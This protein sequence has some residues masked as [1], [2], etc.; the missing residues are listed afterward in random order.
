MNFK[1]GRFFYLAISFIL[2]AFFFIFGAFG[3]ILPWS[4]FLQTVTIQLIIE[5]TLMLSLFG[6][7]FVL[8][9]ISIVIYALLNSRHRYIH[10]RTGG[11]AITLDE[12]II[13]QYVEAYWQGHFPNIHVPF[14]LTFKRHSIQ[15][16]ADLPALPLS[17]QKIFLVRLKHDFSD[18]FGR[19]LGYP[20]DVHLIASFQTEKATSLSN[21]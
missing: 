10:I 9:G 1:L 13:Q 20:Y 12:N 11:Q 18:L 6:L 14:H 4:P 21:S 2:G 7:G 15:I 16:V 5:N 3:I 8:I 19:I 17:E